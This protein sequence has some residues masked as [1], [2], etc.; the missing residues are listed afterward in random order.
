ML[1]DQCFIFKVNPTTELELNSTHAFPPLAEHTHDCIA[2][3]TPIM[4]SNR[5]LSRQYTA[6]KGVMT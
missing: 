6:R 4:D 3:K 1:E 2:P 5:D